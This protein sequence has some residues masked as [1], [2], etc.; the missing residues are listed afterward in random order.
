MDWF[1][2]GGGNTEITNGTSLSVNG[3]SGAGSTYLLNVFKIANTSTGVTGPVY[4]YING[5]LPTNITIYVDNTTEMTFSGNSI[6][7]YSVVQGSGAGNTSASG[8]GF[9]MK[10]PLTSN[11]TA[12]ISFWIKGN[13]SG[14]GKL[15]IQVSG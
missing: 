6:G 10:I 4:V 5:T 8:S 11:H 2:E 13:V 14:N 3:V 15:D 12:Y 1:Q 7:T 9:S